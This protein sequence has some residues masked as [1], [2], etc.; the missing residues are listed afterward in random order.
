MASDAMDGATLAHLGYVVRNMERAVARFEAEGGVLT[1]APT[2]DPVQGVHVALLT[3]D[4]AIDIELVS[5]IVDGSSPVDSRLSRGG[6]LDHVCYFVPDVAAALACDELNGG[7][8][9]C[10]PTYACAFRR[11]IGFVH[12]RSG[13]VVEYM[14]IEE[15]A[16]NGD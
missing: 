16:P 13:L 11:E 9:V 1:L 2:P 5:P 3:V 15:V 12:R 8:T 10:P 4:G 14:S 6:G 7:V